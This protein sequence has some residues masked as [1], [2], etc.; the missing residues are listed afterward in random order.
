MLEKGFSIVD[1]CKQLDCSQQIWYEWKKRDKVF[2]RKVV[3]IEGKVKKDENAIGTDLILMIDRMRPYLQRHCTEKEACAESGI[4]YQT[5]KDI[6]KKMK[7]SD[8][9][10]AKWLIEE[11]ENAK[12]KIFALAKNTLTN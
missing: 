6:K 5:W 9:P 1:I 4:N 7:K 11:I 12:S 10:I 3:E 2:A 8:E